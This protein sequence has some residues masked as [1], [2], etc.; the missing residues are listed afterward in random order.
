MP[1]FDASFLEAIGI[2]SHLAA[3]VAWELRLTVAGGKRLSFGWLM[4]AL[5]HGKE[6]VEKLSK[7]KHPDGKL[8]GFKFWGI[9]WMV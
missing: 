6:V 7:L 4:M 2:R 1:S 3:D 5:T 9:G 8:V